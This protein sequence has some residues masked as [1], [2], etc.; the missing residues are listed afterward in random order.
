MLPHDTE[1]G[2]TCFGFGTLWSHLFWLLA[3]I[4]SNAGLLVATVRVP[5]LRRVEKV[6]RDLDV[7]RKRNLRFE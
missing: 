7:G 4:L 2:G 3:S 6:V 1:G 5:L